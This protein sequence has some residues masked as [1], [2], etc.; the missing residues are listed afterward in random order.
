MVVTHLDATMVIHLTLILITLL[1]TTIV[2]PVVMIPIE[3]PTLTIVIL[4]TDN[5]N[6]ATVE[7]AMITLAVDTL[8]NLTVDTLDTLATLT[9]DAMI[10]LT[11]DTLATLTV[12][13]EDT[14]VADNNA[15]IMSASADLQIDT[16]EEVNAHLTFLP[17]MK[18]PNYKEKTNKLI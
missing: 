12:A 13:T 10:T 14:T 7:D 17:L 18:V 3:L 15:L 9:V 16:T 8:A 5:M 6:L 11:V 4:M 1:I 2:V